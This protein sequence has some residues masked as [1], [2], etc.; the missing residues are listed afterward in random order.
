MGLSAW[1]N[2]PDGRILKSDSKIAKNY[3]SEQEIKSLERS[4]SAFFDYIERIIENQTLLQ[5]S[6]LR[7]V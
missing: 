3:L 4:I 7:A 6:N 1:K 5:W 2:A